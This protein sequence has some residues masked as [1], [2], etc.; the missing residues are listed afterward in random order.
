MA[1]HSVRVFIPRTTH[2]NFNKYPSSCQR[3][4]IAIQSIATTSTSA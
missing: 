2:Y 1:V 4:T 3:C